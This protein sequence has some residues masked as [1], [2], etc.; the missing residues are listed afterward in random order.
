VHADTIV[1]TGHF[2]KAATLLKAVHR[3]PSSVK[4]FRCQLEYGRKLHGDMASTDFAWPLAP[5][6]LFYLT[7]SGWVNDGRASAAL[8]FRYPFPVTH[9]RIPISPMQPRW[10][11]TKPK[12]HH[13]QLQQEVDT[14]RCKFIEMDT[15]QE[16][17][18]CAYGGPP[19][20]VDRVPCS[21]DGVLDWARAFY[22]GDALA[23]HVHPRNTFFPLL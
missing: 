7:V 4:R 13:A 2:R 8:P 15:L 12:D 21:P 10:F 6:T 18:I 17:I 1:L 23:E 20:T 19:D 16:V 9:L 11:F 3:F 22:G 14:L 5:G